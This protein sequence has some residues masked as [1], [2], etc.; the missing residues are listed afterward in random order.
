MNSMKVPYFKPWITSSDKK[1]V[2]KA[3]DQRWLTNGPF[4]FKFEE[5]VRK[6]INSKYTI[7]CSTATHA[8]HLSLKSIGISKNDEV[9][10]PTLTFAATSDVVKYCGA[11]P[12]LCD[13]DLNTFNISPKEIEKKITKKTKAV[14]IVHYGGQACD[15]KEILILSKKYNFS[16]IEDCA[17]ALGS[18]YK[19]NYCGTMGK[20]GCF[21]FYPTKI[22][23]TGEGG[24]ITTNNKNIHDKT[25][26][27]RSHGMTRNPK[28]RESNADWKYDILEMGYNYRLDEI[29]SSLGLS[30]IKRINQIN[31]KRIKIAKKYSKGLKLISGITIPKIKKDR[32]HIFHL[33]TIRITEDYPIN[34]DQLFQ[35]LHKKGI[36]ASVQYIPLHLMSYHKNNC[37]SSDFPNA[38]ILK[39][40]IISLPIYPTM[41]DKQIDF[42]ISILKN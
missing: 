31:N 10:V 6:Y 34:R 15:M 8:L 19:N 7:G 22:I 27:L 25:K 5:K 40:Q 21:S 23:T 35:K 36:G 29:R 42:V 30:Q 16:I 37:K 39:D 2:L 12:V 20:A 33:Y 1:N 18:T 14:I 26:L 13:V 41:T 17:H 38:S 9:I 4:L 24:M 3:L 28:E 32:N 11:K